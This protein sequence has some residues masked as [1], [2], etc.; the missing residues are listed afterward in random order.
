MVAA[1][2][3]PWLEQALRE[4]SGALEDGAQQQQLERIRDILEIDR[5]GASLHAMPAPSEAVLAV[6]N[7][8]SPADGDAVLRERR[9]FVRAEEQPKVP[10]DLRA[11]YHAWVSA[12]IAQRGGVYAIARG[13]DRGLHAFLYAHALGL[14]N[15]HAAWQICEFYHVPS[16]FFLT[17]GFHT[18][19]CVSSGKTVAP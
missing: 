2:L 13:D 11:A 5:G 3:S 16:V 12:C 7:V 14:P 17:F 9:A 15:A 18:I 10:A 19:L 4:S 8:S 6:L 1:P